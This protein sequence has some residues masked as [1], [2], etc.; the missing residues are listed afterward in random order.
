MGNRCWSIVGAERTEAPSRV[1]KDTAD[2]L[3]C[4]R[5]RAKRPAKTVRAGTALRTPLRDGMEEDVTT[6]GATTERESPADT[7]RP[8]PLATIRLSGG[9]AIDIWSEI[10]LHTVLDRLMVHGL[11]MQACAS[12]ICEET[13]DCASAITTKE[14]AEAVCAI[15]PPAPVV[16]NEIPMATADVLPETKQV[17]AL[18]PPQEPEVAGS[19]H[20]ASAQDYVTTP[21]LRRRI[22]KDSSWVAT[23]AVPA[24]RVVTVTDTLKLQEA[25]AHG[26]PPEDI[27]AA[28]GRPPDSVVETFSICTPRPP[29]PDVDADDAGGSKVETIE[30]AIATAIAER[31]NPVSG[32]VPLTDEN[33]DD[34][35]NLGQLSDPA[36][37][38][39]PAMLAEEASD[40][41]G[42]AS[43]APAVAKTAAPVPSGAAEEA[44]VTN[45]AARRATA[46]WHE[47]VDSDEESP[48]DGTDHAGAERS[49]TLPDGSMPEATRPPDPKG[50]TEVR[51]KR[52]RRKA[53]EGPAV[54]DALTDVST[55]LLEVMSAIA[56]SR[57][58]APVRQALERCQ[59]MEECIALISKP[60]NRLEMRKFTAAVLDEGRQRADDLDRLW[61]RGA[62]SSA[63]THLVAKPPWKK[64]RSILERLGA[65]L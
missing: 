65:V 35:T 56:Y 38:G 43:T 22:A 14:R 21:Q 25:E 28:P 17:E 18:R 6:V 31:G 36:D 49:P 24:V 60:H 1:R 62:S 27:E 46:R 7:P 58:P 32:L 47:V 2:L 44:S 40:D 45:Q 48:E 26:R 33:E 30:E 3:R 39:V 37:T 34:A 51:R 9:A 54:D 19:E 20:P 23:G 41:P 64:T 13:A 50:Y 53:E 4:L 15:P 16:T 12:E 57:T 63:V 11:A 55:I 5:G 10:A 42:E 8:T 59:E 61:G 29:G 52:R